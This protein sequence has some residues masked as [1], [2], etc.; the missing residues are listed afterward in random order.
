MP[1]TA[2]L[3]VGAPRRRNALVKAVRTLWPTL[4][5]LVLVG[6]ISTRA[7]SIPVPALIFM[8]PVAFAAVR[9]G[10]ILGFL[11]AA[12]ALAGIGFCLL[13]SIDSPA[14]LDQDAIAHL[15]LSGVCFACLVLIV[16]QPRNL[17]HQEALPA[18]DSIFRQMA[19]T[20]GEVFWVTSAD[21]NK[22]HYVNPA[23]EKVWGRPCA[24]LYA[25]ADLWM[26]AIHPEDAAEVRIAFE[27]LLGEEPSISTTGSVVRTAR[28]C[29]SA[30]VDTWSV[31]MPAR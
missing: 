12:I 24:E 29:G 31:M 3:P 5:A 15:A 22:I 18:S 17:V 19:E 9:G 20:I 21:G 7:V 6:L 11:A 28:S 10:R 30:T 26:E 13:A 16:G 2:R 1:S 4:L 14:R 27:A 23:F 25:N 8:V